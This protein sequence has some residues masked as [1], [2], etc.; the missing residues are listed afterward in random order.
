MARGLFCL[1]IVSKIRN[2]AKKV[3]EMT[4]DKQKETAKENIKKAQQGWTK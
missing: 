1:I 3:N 4:T 2:I